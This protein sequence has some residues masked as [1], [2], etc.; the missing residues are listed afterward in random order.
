MHPTDMF[1][2]T[3]IDGICTTSIY[4]GFNLAPSVYP[5]GLYIL[6]DVFL[7]NVVAVFDVGNEQIH[8]APHNNY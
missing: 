2:P 8:F 3:G 6:G 5:D 1:V 7:H 4:R